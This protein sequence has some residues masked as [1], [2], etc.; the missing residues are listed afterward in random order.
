MAQ[1]RSSSREGSFKANQTTVPDEVQKIQ[2]A[3]ERRLRGMTEAQAM[4]EKNRQVFE[5]AQSINQRL[6]SQGIQAATKVRN[7]R[8]DTIES[9]AEK[10]WRAEERQNEIRRKEKEATLKQL[11]QFSQTAFNIAAG[12]VKQNKENFEKKVNQLA[13]VN[14]FDSDTLNSISQLDREM[15]QAEYQRTDFVQESI[16]AGKNQ[17]WVDAT[18]NHLLKGGGYTNYIEVAS[19]LKNQGI[20]HST[21]YQEVLADATLTPEEKERKINHIEAAN[22]ASLTVNGKTPSAEILEQ[23]YFPALRRAKASALGELAKER[24]DIV[25]FESENQRIQQYKVAMQG[26]G[27]ELEYQAGWSLFQTKPSKENRVEFTQLALGMGDLEDNIR[28]KEAKF[29]GPNGTMVSL[30]DYP[31]T[32]DLINRAIR[33]KR[34]EAK[35]TYDENVQLEYAQNELKIEQFADSLSNDEN[36]FTEADYK[37]VQQY[38]RSEFGPGHDSQVVKSLE[39]FTVTAQAAPQMREA[40]DEYIESGYATLGGLEAFGQL[41]EP[42]RNY[43]VDR[44]NKQ[45]KIQNSSEYQAAL[46]NFDKTIKGAIKASSGEDFVPGGYNSPDLQWYAGKSR[47]KF[48]ERLKNYSATT[49]DINKAIELAQNDT[50]RAIQQDLDAPGAITK[51]GQLAAYQKY[52]KSTQNDSRKARNM[53]RSIILFSGS[54]DSKTNGKPDAKK[55]VDKFFNGGEQIIEA[56]EVYQRTGSTTFFEELGRQIQF[57][58]AKAPWEVQAWFAEAVDGLEPIEPPTTWE[59]IKEDVT[60]EQRR[61]LFGPESATQEKVRVL[62][63]VARD[64]TIPVRPA[65]QV[66]ESRPIS[67]F[68]NQARGQVTFD[69]GQ[70]GIDVFFEDK[71]FPAVLPG[72]VKE[73]SSQYNAD[74]SGYGNFIVIES[75]DPE[76]NEPVDVL[77]GHL[78]DTA[79]FKQGDSISEGQIIGE[80]GGT[81]SVQSVDGTIASI[82][83]LAPAA[84]G[85]GSMKPYTN[86]DSLRR[87]IARDLGFN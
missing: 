64:R 28:L 69:T 56:T 77:Y 81:G 57:E 46:E 4:L 32:R 22:V 73:V 47:Q 75:I 11:S 17:E 2:K 87:R 9:N 16:K 27:S 21:A 35:R 23:H 86:Y 41:P 36:R 44:I 79:Q 54:P 5:R 76:T 20:K 7:Q 78:A 3:G 25:E 72:I 31:E 66:G 39:G 19:V 50:I 59:A 62:R 52:L 67:T 82:D 42:L 34:L 55:W 1:F 65:Y 10:A 71:K 80:Q 51:S 14:S 26:D 43:A 60:R 74:G 48:L 40:L 37:R 6:T 83:F 29:E 58:E 68:A 30:M 45:V 24:R 84:P 33:D 12:I 61:I 53:A 63:E 13:L 38:A 70:P 18:Y 15:T 49:P 85:S 8:L